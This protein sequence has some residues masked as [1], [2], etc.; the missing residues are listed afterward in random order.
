MRPKLPIFSKMP[1][2]TIDPA[3]GASTWALGN[4]ICTKYKGVFTI[5]AKEIPIA[6]QP[7]KLGEKTKKGGEFKNKTN[8]GRLAKIV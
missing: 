1:A 2:K 7:E 5:K 3:T 8:K 6:N 4:Q